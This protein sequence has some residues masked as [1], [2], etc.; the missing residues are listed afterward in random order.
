MDQDI[1]NAKKVNIVRKMLRLSYQEYADR[2]GF[3]VSHLNAII[4]GDRSLERSNST[5]KA[6][7]RALRRRALARE[8][9]QRIYEGLCLADGVEP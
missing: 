3:S 4:T 1:F 6:R 8:N 7:F 9:G 5:A 2:L